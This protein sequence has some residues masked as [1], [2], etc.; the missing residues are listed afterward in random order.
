LLTVLPTVLPDRL[1]AYLPERITLVPPE[2]WP[3]VLTGGFERTGVRTSIPRYALDLR[4]SRDEVDPARVRWLA[5]GSTIRSLATRHVH[6]AAHLGMLWIVDGYTALAAH[7]AARTE[8]IPVRLVS[9][10]DASA[11]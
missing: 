7:L 1:T 2:A 11:G 5:E 4:T 3:V 10:I 6:V 8:A 9:P